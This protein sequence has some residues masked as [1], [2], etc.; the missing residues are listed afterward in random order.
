MKIII[1]NY[2]HAREKGEQV[3]KNIANLTMKEKDL[4]DEASNKAI[5]EIKILIFKQIDRLGEEKQELFEDIFAKTFKNENKSKYI[6]YYNE[7]CGQSESEDE[8]V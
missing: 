8:E 6:D 7:L 1:L 3:N 4:N 2:L 5:D